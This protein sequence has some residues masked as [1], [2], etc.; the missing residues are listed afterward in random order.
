M[1]YFEKDLADLSQGNDV[2]EKIKSKAG[3]FERLKKVRG[4]RRASHVHVLK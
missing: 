3:K 1:I 4:F 2:C